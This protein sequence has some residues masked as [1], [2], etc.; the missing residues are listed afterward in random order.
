MPSVSPR[1]VG[2]VCVAVAAVVAVSLLVAWATAPSP[3]TIVPPDGDAVARVEFALGSDA[4][5]DGMRIEAESV[6]IVTLYLDINT[7]RIEDDPDY[8]VEPND[9]RQAMAEQYVKL[10]RPFT[11][12]VSYGIVDRDNMVRPLKT[13]E[14]VPERTQPE[15][16][17][18][19]FTALASNQRRVAIHFGRCLFP[20]DSGSYGLLVIR[21]PRQSGDGTPLGVGPSEP[22]TSMPLRTVPFTLH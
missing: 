20:S 16:E 3:R 18:T 10:I 9:D 22:T 5:T 15:R 17:P 4:M 21:R 14:R 11:G 8:A 19:S 7:D 2:F 12:C 1:V 6:H 13:L